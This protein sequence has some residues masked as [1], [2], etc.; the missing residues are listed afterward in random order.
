[1]SK[2][3]HSAVTKYPVGDF[4]TGL[5]IDMFAIFTCIHIN[6][7]TWGMKTTLMYILVK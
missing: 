5:R 7:I 4:F 2:I 1:M 6:N 3:D